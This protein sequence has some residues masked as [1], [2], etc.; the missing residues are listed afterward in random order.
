MSEAIF[1]YIFPL[2]KQTN[3]KKAREENEG[4]ISGESPKQFSTPIDL[5]VII[6]P[7]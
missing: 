1:Y 4:C 7:K 3:K 5:K 6:G 2:K